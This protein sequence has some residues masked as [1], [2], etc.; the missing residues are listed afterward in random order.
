MTPVPTDRPRADGRDDDIMSNIDS[1]QVNGGE[2]GWHWSDPL[3]DSDKGLGGRVS[4]IFLPLTLNSSQRE[5]S[6]KH[7]ALLNCGMFQ[8]VLLCLLRHAFL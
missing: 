6:V 4:L 1:A 7:Q 5:L 3:W 2:V 8:L